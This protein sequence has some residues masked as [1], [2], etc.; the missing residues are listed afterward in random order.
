MLYLIKEHHIKADDV[1]EVICQLPS[2]L[3]QTLTYSRPETGL[4]GMFS[5][6]Y[7]MAAALLDGEISPRVFTDDKVRRTEARELVTRVKCVPTEVGMPTD[8]ALRLPQRV[9]VKVKNGKEYSHEVRFPRGDIRNPM[10]D[11]EINDKFRECASLTFTTKQIARVLDLTWNL[12]SLPLLSNLT[13][14]LF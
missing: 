6:E 9:T 13:D 1:A 11:E 10:T 3:A 8:E 14:L 7:C 5:M 2:V 4:E 12:E